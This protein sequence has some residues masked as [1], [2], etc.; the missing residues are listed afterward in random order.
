MAGEV[1]DKTQDIKEWVN[2]EGTT[3]LTSLLKQ[4]YPRAH[5]T[6]LQPGFQVTPVRE[7]PQPL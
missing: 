6:G 5:F 2:L 7:T 1:Q 3:G 4:A